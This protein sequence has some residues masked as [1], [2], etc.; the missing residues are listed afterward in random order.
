M[1]AV[2][3]GFMDLPW[4]LRHRCA[5]GDTSGLWQIAPVPA[6]VFS[7]VMVASRVMLIVLNA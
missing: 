4:A 6:V 3:V 7:G 2:N 5:A 1:Y